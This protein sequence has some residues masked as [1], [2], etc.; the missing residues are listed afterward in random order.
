MKVQII[1]LIFSDATS[2]EE[3]ADLAA[4]SSSPNIES[5]SRPDSRSSLS[6]IP[7]QQQVA[8]AHLLSSEDEGMTFWFYSHTNFSDPLFWDKNFRL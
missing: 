3:A 1:V 2:L 5:G 7:Q 6:P 8:E 4:R